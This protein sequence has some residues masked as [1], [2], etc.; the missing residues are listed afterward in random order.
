[1]AAEQ[2]GVPVSRLAVKDGVVSDK[3]DGK[4]QVTY[5]QLTQGKIIEKRLPAK[6][7]MKKVSEF[8]VMGRSYKRTDSLQ[9]VTGHAPYAGDIFRL[10]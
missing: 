5:A 1:M 6:P 9:K 7:P 4:R 8:K 10:L 3:K 2:F